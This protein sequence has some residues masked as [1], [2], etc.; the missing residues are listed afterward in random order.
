MTIFV[1]ALSVSLFLAVCL[2]RYVNEWH[3]ARLKEIHQETQANE[4]KLRKAL[5]S[6]RLLKAQT[7][8]LENEVYMLERELRDLRGEPDPDEDF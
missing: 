2:Q 4:R 5:R 1:I 6:Q 3:A 7:L 8:S